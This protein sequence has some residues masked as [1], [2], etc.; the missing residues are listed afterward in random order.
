MPYRIGLTGGIGSGKSQVARFLEAWGATIVDADVISRELMLPGSQLLG[1]LVDAWGDDILQPDG[2]LHRAALAA[3]VFGRP[4]QVQRLNV[5]AHPPI[6]REMECRAAA[7]QTSVVVLMAPLLLEAGG[8]AVDE[9]WA[10]TC[11]PAIRQARVVARDQVSMDDVSRRMA[12]QIDDAERAAQAQVLIPNEGSLEE[13]R[14][15]VRCAWEQMLQR[16]TLSGAL[17]PH[18]GA[19]EPTP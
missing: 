6:M 16:A 5:L 2:T 15:V 17:H 8:G 10:V 14:T 12:A 3:K 11:A 1:Q 18:P 9:V 7:A 4:E 13:L 19:K